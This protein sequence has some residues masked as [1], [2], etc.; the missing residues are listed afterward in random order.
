MPSF[1]CTASTLKF[2]MRA[3]YCFYSFP[4]ICNSR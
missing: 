4:I 3:P 1:H 2:T